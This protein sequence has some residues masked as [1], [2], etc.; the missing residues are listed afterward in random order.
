MQG[1]WVY[2]WLIWDVLLSCFSDL[3][4]QWNLLLHCREWMPCW[5]SATHLL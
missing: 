1:G 4:V 2:E 3:S 5:A